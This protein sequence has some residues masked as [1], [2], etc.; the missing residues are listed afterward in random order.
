[1]PLMRCLVTRPQAQALPL[2]AQ[3]RALGVDAAALPL[4]AIAPPADPA[5]V[6]AAWARLGDCALA[7][8]VSANAVE[9]FFALRPPDARWPDSTRAGA[10]GPGTA[11]ALHAAGVPAGAIDAPSA[12]PYESEALW[13]LWQPHARAGARALIVRGEHGRDWLASRLRAAGVRVD[14][15]AAYARRPPGLDAAAQALLAQALAAPGAHAWLFSSS[16]AIAQLGALA[17]DADWAAATALATHPRIGAAA[18][19]FGFGRVLDAAVA[20][21]ELGAQLRSLQSA[22]P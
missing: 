14:F 8:F 12:P 11:A 19:A 22:P 4:I 2:V 7:M 9:G 15:V 20:L 17:P 16:E 6:A 5:A 18:R 21:P 1:M 3:L 13:P 10:T